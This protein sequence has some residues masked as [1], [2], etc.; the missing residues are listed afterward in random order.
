MKRNL[1]KPTLALAAMAA[2]LGVAVPV[3]LGASDT[4]TGLTAT[5]DVALAPNSQ[6]IK[7]ATITVTSD[8]KNVLKGTEAVCTSAAVSS[9]LPVGGFGFRLLSPTFNGC[10]NSTAGQ[11]YTDTVRTAGTWSGR[12]I[13][14]SDAG[15]EVRGASGDKV[16][17]TVPKN[18]LSLISG[19]APTCVI[20][21]NP[22]GNNPPLP[23]AYN[24][25]T[26]QLTIMNAHITF[27]VGS[28]PGAQCPIAGDTGTALAS[29]TFATSPAVSDN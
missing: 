7:Q 5:I 1:T 29:A 23:G 28:V 9:P 21:E 11:Q 13:D 18:G 17:T 22:A 14:G 4:D 16:L 25:A 19:A 2:T 3:V 15:G 8:S 6:G 12:Y 26:G 24:D 27:T 20:S 10:T